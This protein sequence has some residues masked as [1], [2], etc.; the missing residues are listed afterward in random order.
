MLTWRS[1][2]AWRCTTGDRGGPMRVRDTAA[3][4][5]Q[6]DTGHR[7]TDCQHQ[8]RIAG[9][10]GEHYRQHQENDAAEF[11][12]RGLARI[13]LQGSFPPSSFIMT[14]EP[15]SCKQR[16][17]ANRATG[18]LKTGRLSPFCPSATA[19]PLYSWLCAVA[20]TTCMVVRQAADRGAFRE[21]M[22]RIGI[23]AS[24]LTFARSYRNAGSSAY[25]YHLLQ[26]LPGLASNAPFRGV[27]QRRPARTGGCA[28]TCASRW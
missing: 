24:L 18:R 19:I 15:L 3:R 26:Q 10:N 6:H 9:G 1:I 13:A 16:Y 2:T 21:C 4:G 11:Q 12:C 7:R 23:N 22:A 28:V 17:A 14:Y 5:K 20:E 27:Y 8:Q 25:I